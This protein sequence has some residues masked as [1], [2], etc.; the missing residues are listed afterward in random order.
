MNNFV[1][2]LMDVA[3]QKDVIIGLNID[4]RN[5]INL[6]SPEMNTYHAKTVLRPMD[7]ADKY[8]E[9]ENKYLPGGVGFRKYSRKDLISGHYK[10]MAELYPK[11]A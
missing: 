4:R 7:E 10:I 8:L 5:K 3:P 2:A 1:G 9:L 11:T 6:N